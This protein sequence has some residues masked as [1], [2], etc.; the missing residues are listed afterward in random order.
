MRVFFLAVL[1]VC[2]PGLSLLA[3]ESDDKTIKDLVSDIDRARGPAEGRWSSDDPDS[4]RYIVPGL[5]LLDQVKKDHTALMKRDPIAGETVWAKLYQA[6]L[7]IAEDRLDEALKTLEDLVAQDLPLDDW[8][9]AARLLA[10]VQAKKWLIKPLDE[11]I[12]EMQK[13]G[14]DAGETKR[15]LYAMEV[16]IRR[17]NTP[18]ITPESGTYDSDHVMMSITVPPK[19]IVLFTLDGSEPDKKTAY[20]YRHPVK[21]ENTGK[22]VIVRARAYERNGVGVEARAIFDM[23]LKN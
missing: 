20:H 11:N 4:F 18:V 10:E 21:I 17:R 1:T 15:A 19:L 7:D 14:A 8:S 23:H 16:F 12:K 13:R 6:N 5:Q 3:Q 9:V 2:L 22:P